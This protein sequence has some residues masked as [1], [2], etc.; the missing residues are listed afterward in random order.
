MLL[1]R[2]DGSHRLIPSHIWKRSVQR[3]PAV[4]PPS[5][6]N[7]YYILE[8]DTTIFDGL[9]PSK[10]D[11]TWRCPFYCSKVGDVEDLQDYAQGLEETGD[12]LEERNEVYPDSKLEDDCSYCSNN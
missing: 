7:R 11:K 1:I 9:I 10:E 4:P 5:I 3:L 12:G 6:S 8:L 2:L